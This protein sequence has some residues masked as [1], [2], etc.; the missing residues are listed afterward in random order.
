MCATHYLP[1]FV[2]PILQAMAGVVGVPYIELKS[3]KQFYFSE[4]WQFELNEAEVLGHL[5]T[6]LF[7]CIHD[8]CAAA[9]MIKAGGKQLVSER[10]SAVHCSSPSCRITS[11]WWLC[12]VPCTSPCATPRN[13]A[14][15]RN[16]GFGA[17]LRFI[18]CARLSTLRPFCK[19]GAACK[20]WGTKQSVPLGPAAGR[21][22]IIHMC[23]CPF[24][25][26]GMREGFWGGSH[27]HGVTQAWGG[28]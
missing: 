4:R 3:H 26:P 14:S 27:L 2:P 1:H 12:E 28:A 23:R 25:P 15:G 19:R 7:P 17:V 9:D 13:P 11:R 8:I 10:L 18:A 21:L 22:V 5:Q 24:G 6:L 16:C 20:A